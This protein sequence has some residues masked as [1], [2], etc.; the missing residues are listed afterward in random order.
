MHRLIML[1]NSRCVRWTGWQR[2]AVGLEDSIR[3][4]MGMDRHH[5]AFSHLCSRVSVVVRPP[6]ALARRRKVFETP[7]LQI[8]TRRR[9]RHCSTHGRDDEIR[10]SHDRRSTIHRLFQRH[11]S[12]AYG[13]R[14]H[15]L[16]FASV[17]W[18]RYHQLRRFAYLVRHP[19]LLPDREG[20]K[21]KGVHWRRHL[22]GLLLA[23]H[24]LPGLC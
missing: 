23:D 16:A 17:R 4:A 3:S 20:R 19:V 8:S 10:A 6:G 14:L 22:D 7:H 1:H 9:S 18:I 15:L 13:D 24:R 12:L 11:E 21:T 2:N 5:G